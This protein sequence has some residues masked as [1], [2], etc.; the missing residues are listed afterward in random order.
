ME[1]RTDENYRAYLRNHILPRWGAVALGSISALEVT[2]WVNDLRQRYAAS[3]V[4]GIVTVF[5]M[6]LDDA[7]D[8]HL[9]AVNSVHRRLRGRRRDNAPSRN[10]RVWTMPD[11]VLRIADQARALGGPSAALLIITAAWT[12]CRWGELAGLQR[13]R[14][15]VRR[16]TITI[17]PDTDSG[18]A[19]PRHLPRPAPS[20]CPDSSPGSCR[21]TSPP[22]VCRTTRRRVLAS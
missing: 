4:A 2:A 9:I 22:P 11:H 5:S 8:E 3:T 13:H 7:I 21:C 6:M 20:P 17:D 19:R 10:E 1:T 14:V 15:N 16:R 12:V 18:S